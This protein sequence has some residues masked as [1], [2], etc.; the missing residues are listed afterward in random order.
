MTAATWVPKNITQHSDKPNLWFI[1]YYVFFMAFPCMDFFGFSV[2]FYFFLFLLY[3]KGSMLFEAFT[4]PFTLRFFFYLFLL[5]AFISTFLAVKCDRPP[6]FQEDLRFYIQHI[7]WVSMAA[8]FI[9]FGRHLNILELSKFV[10]F[11]VTTALF[12][13]YAPFEA[14]FRSAI[15]SINTKPNRNGVLYSCL[16]LIPFAFYYI[17]KR[18]ERRGAIIFLI[19]YNLAIIFTNGRSGTIVF[20]IE[21]LLIIQILF[22]LAKIGFKVLL[23]VFGILSYM[24]SSPTVE[25][26]LQAFADSIE[27][28]NPRLANLIRGEKEGDLNEDRSWLFRLIMVEKAQEINQKYPIFGVGINHFKAMDGSLRFSYINRRVVGMDKFEMNK[29]SAHNSYYQLL[30]ENGFFGLACVIALAFTPIFT[31]LFKVIFDRKLTYS[32]LPQAALLGISIHWYSIA[33]FMGGVTW[34]CIGLAIYGLRN[35]Y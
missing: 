35:K 30:A 33:S 25:P 27:G 13:F 9:I 3:Y 18:Y 1:N 32:D 29:G 14:E 8:F 26:L 31:L 17:H 22:P 19:I 11:G 5:G 12:F 4:G 21:T 34:I 24:S 15:F 10:F 20:F 28:A 6:P 23:I 7:Y 16:A 2:T